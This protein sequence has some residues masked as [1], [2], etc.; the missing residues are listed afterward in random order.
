MGSTAGVI[1]PF[2]SAAP[3]YDSAFTDTLL[4]RL[5][6]EAVWRSLD[7]AFPYGCRVLELNCGTGEDARYLAER[8]VSVVATD[9]SPGMLGVARRKLESLES[10]CRPQLRELDL[11]G[12]SLRG[13]SA[14]RAHLEIPRGERFDGVLSNFGGL[15][16]VQDL[17]GLAV[18]LASLLRPGA[19][20]IFCIMGRYVP[21]EWAWFLWRR[22]LRAAFRR[23]RGS[24]VW[25]GVTIRYPTPGQVARVFRPHCRLR[26]VKAL[27][28]LLP[29]PYA[30]AWAESRPALVDRLNR[31]ERRMESALPLAWLADHYVLELERREFLGG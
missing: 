5:L 16:C 3:G 13:A 17:P 10:S 25:R 27:G 21:W 9:G 28:A 31:W 8:G 15:N 29:P 23:V 2:D 20:A 26:D 11:E 22:D 1:D 6:R 18:G 14:V 30:N 7:R 12:W 19:I 24:A 4:G